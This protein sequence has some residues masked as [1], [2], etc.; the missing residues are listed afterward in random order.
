MG[1]GAPYYAPRLLCRILCFPSRACVGARARA[2]E[3]FVR[4][5]CFF[6]KTAAWRF[7]AVKKVGRAEA[8]IWAREE[9]LDI[10]CL[11]I[12][13][14]SRSNAS[15]SDMHYTSLRDTPY[16]SHTI[17]IHQK[18]R[19][20]HTPSQTPPMPT[21]SRRSCVSASTT[22]QTPPPFP[23]PPNPLWI[24]APRSP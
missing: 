16:T 13:R 24:P 10:R 11:R 15:L 5:F 12:Q 7:C 21:V 6:F 9:R 19:Y 1:W 2:Y 4:I 18:T 17:P 20:I 22:A 8:R 23:S 3:V 14:E